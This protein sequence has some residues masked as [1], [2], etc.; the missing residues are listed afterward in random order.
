MSLQKISDIRTKK[1]PKPELA[2]L[3]PDEVR[4]VLEPIPT[5]SL[6]GRRD[7]ALLTLLYDSAARVQEICGLR[8][9]D[10]RLQKPYTIKLT[11]K[12]QK[13][14]WVPVMSGTADILKNMSLKT[15]WVRR[16][17]QTVH[18]SSTTGILFLPEPASHIY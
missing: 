12:G 6:Y 7:L 18:F 10:I 5:D 17:K 4:A 13:A 1:H 16:K 14:R 11:G 9:R 15:V 2:Y 8:V 3:T